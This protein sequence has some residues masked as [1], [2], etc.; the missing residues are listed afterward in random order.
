MTDDP[1]NAAPES[2]FDDFDIGPQSD[3]FVPDEFEDEDFIDD[4]PPGMTDVEADAD[5]LASA[6][7]GTDEDYGYYGDDCYL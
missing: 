4:E 1:R 7:W 6:G 3:E 5:T 2:E